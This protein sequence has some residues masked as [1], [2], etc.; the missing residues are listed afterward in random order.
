MTSESPNGR[1]PELAA[2]LI[3]LGISTKDVSP[4]ETN[5]SIAPTLEQITQLTE[6][7]KEIGRLEGVTVA[8]P[9]ISR[10]G[11]EAAHAAWRILVHADTYPHLQSR[12]AELMQKEA[13][14]D[15]EQPAIAYMLDRWLI[16]SIRGE[17]EPLGLQNYG[18]QVEFIPDWESRQSRLIFTFPPIII[19]NTAAKNQKPRLWRAHKFENINLERLNKRRAELG[20]G[21]FEIFVNKQIQKRRKEGEKVTAL[22]N[23]APW[24][25]Q[26]FLRQIR[27]ETA[28]QAAR[29]VFEHAPEN[30]DTVI[31]EEQ[32]PPPVY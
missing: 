29:I 8:W 15:V 30:A 21:D 32:P 25:Q 31:T 14:E 26:T 22:W 3:S 13:P 6:I 7:C 12:A 11:A 23:L 2:S 9:S 16:N 1:Y 4:H 24:E 28:V 19:R 5:P 10:V 17:E 20:L 18:T 27:V